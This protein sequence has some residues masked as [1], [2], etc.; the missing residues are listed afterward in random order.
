VVGIGLVPGGPIKSFLYH[1][2]TLSPIKGPH[3]QST[4][5]LD[6]NGLGQIVGWY[7]SGQGFLRGP[8]GQYTKLHVPFPGA[9]GSSATAI[10]K[11]GHIIGA[12]QDPSVDETGIIEDKPLGFVAIPGD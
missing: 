3:A 1:D 9:Q 4:Q 5:V 8:K 12:Y 11:S 10:N 7:G 6:V 2:G